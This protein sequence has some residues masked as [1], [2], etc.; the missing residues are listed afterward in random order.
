MTSMFNSTPFNQPIGNWNI[1]GV[2]NF[3]FF[4]LNKTTSTL[5]SSNLDNI[6]NGWVTKNPQIGITITFGSAKHTSGSTTNKNI[7]TSTY[8]WFITDGGVI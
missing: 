2:T 4:M 8:G 6:Y 7:L 1:S 3:N 5:S